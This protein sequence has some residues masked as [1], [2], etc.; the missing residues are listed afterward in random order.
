MFQEIC[1]NN[2]EWD[3]LLLVD[4]LKKW[5]LWSNKLALLLEIC[6]PRYLFSEILPSTKFGLLGFCATQSYA[7]VCYIRVFD[8]SSQRY[9]CRIVAA[10]SKVAPVKQLTIPRLE[11]PGCLV[12]S[13][14]ISKI[15]SALTKCHLIACINCWIDST[16]ALNWFKNIS[17]TREKWVENRLTT[18]RNLV[19]ESNW[20][21][22]PTTTSPA[23]IPTRY[24]NPTTFSSNQ[25]WWNGP[26]YLES[27]ESSWPD[28]TIIL[29]KRHSKEDIVDKVAKVVTSTAN[30]LDITNISNINPIE[31]FSSL[32]RLL[33]VTCFVNRFINNTQK[34][35]KKLAGTISFEEKDNALNTWIQCEQKCVLFSEK[36][37]QQCKSLQLFLDKDNLYHVRNLFDNE[38][39]LFDSI[40]TVFLPQSLLITYKFDYIRRSQKSNACR[41]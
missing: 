13:K 4:I 17:K 20:I 38:K 2:F 12:L 14:L 27:S 10:K 31:K 33:V 22:V 16:A 9:K 6:I 18:I 1:L 32:Q 39:M 37:K 41:Y 3:S 21:Y 25:L 30:K 7:A 29:S 15:F 34:S 36:F 40:Y 35:K 24:C 8:S 11:R 19:N 26:S 23:D 28:Q 5:E